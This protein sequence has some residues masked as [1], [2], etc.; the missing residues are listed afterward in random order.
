[1]NYNLL[2][3]DD[4]QFVVGNGDSSFSIAKY[5][6]DDAFMEKLRMLPRKGYFDGGMVQPEPV[7]QPGEPIDLPIDAVPYNPSS[8]EIGGVSPESIYSG[9]QMLEAQ[10]E[11][12]D[13]RT[14][15]L[16]AARAAD[17]AL[18]Q[19]RLTKGFNLTP[20]EQEAAFTPVAPTPTAAEPAPMQ[21]PAVG[22]DVPGYL[23][24][25]QD[26]AATGAA[27]S[28]AMPP[29]IMSAYEK[30]RAGTQAQAQAHA[31][32]AQEQAR[33]YG[34]QEADLKLLELRRT[35]NLE[36]L[37]ND[38]KQIQNSIMTDK[39]NPNRVWQNMS[40]GNRVLASIGIMLGGLS[41]GLG[42]RKD[43]PAMDVINAA[44]DRDIDAQKS[45][46]G[47]KQNLLSF[48]L[49]QYGR[50]DQAFAATKMQLL[51]ITQAQLNKTAAQMGSKQAL[52]AAQVAS[53]Q[54]DLQMATLKNKLASD[55]AAAQRMQEPKGLGFDDL[56]K[57]D[58]K[59]REVMVPIPP[60]AGDQFKNRFIPAVTKEDATKIKTAYTLY[61]ET[62][63]LLQRVKTAMD[64]GFTLPKTA[65]NDIAQS[66]KSELILLQKKL[67]QLGQITEADMDLVNPLIPTVGTLF[68][69]G[70]RAKLDT[71]FKRND[72]L[73]DAAYMGKTGYNRAA[74]RQVEK[75][76]FRSP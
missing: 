50:M 33:L 47:K 37:D 66:L 35:K 71:L 57:L 34:E 8:I 9:R 31:Q 23:K 62:L 14:L 69:K 64:K 28:F 13:Q 12:A 59:T 11:A 46:L 16:E 45:E 21:A 75:P 15:D 3:E 51:G 42:N 1:M 73:I 20:A 65:Q 49:A 24:L 39:I 6:L 70:E 29:D 36:K 61:Q 53:G 25:M 68:D 30:M 54:L 38:I 4:N 17:E 58:E 7:V 26:M 5:G 76:V 32:A 22:G 41:Q 63:P 74:Y 60:T 52:A 55:Y 48:N 10:Q 44:I 40:T 56:M 72:E 2:D 27:P 18:R 19:E 67:Q 43:N